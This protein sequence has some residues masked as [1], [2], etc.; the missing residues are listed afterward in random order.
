M[1][2]WI[3]AFLLAFSGFSGLTYLVSQKE[4]E[5]VEYKSIKARLERIQGELD[6]CQDFRKKVGL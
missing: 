3:L 4:R 5:Q 2:H 6:N 1:I